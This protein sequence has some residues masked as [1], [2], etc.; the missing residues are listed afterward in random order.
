MVCVSN[1]QTGV[2]SA[3]SKDSLR[4]EDSISN[5]QDDE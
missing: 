2:G 1:P 3:D 4:T 5:S